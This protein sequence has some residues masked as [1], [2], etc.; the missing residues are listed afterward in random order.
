MQRY[1][2]RT[3]LPRTGIKRYYLKIRAGVR[4]RCLICSPLVY[5]RLY[6]L[7]ASIS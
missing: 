5:C 2:E 1:T 7:R 3:H 6:D 4:K